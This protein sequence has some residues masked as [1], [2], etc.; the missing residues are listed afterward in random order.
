[1]INGILLI[2]K[3]AGWTSHDVVKKVKNLLHLKKAGHA[4]TLDPMATGLLLLCLNQATRHAT[5]LLAADKTYLAS[6]SL[7]RAT[8]T[9]DSEGRVIRE[10]PVPLLSLDKIKDVLEG[11]M[12]TIEQI[13]PMYSAIKHQGRPLYQW[14]RAGK[15][16]ERLPRPITIN[17]LKLL[18]YSPNRIDLYIECSKGTYIRS[19]V[20]AIAEKLGTV[21]HLTQLRRMRCG[22]FVVEKAISIQDL[23]RE[24]KNGEFDEE[25][26]VIALENKALQTKTA[27]LA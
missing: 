9:E 6:L 25:K 3:P 23:E 20:V 21:G 17:Q 2:D 12:G 19:L 24:V 10:R 13:P 15:T 22:D 11:F 8:D 18:K 1:M 27:M 5:C 7:G 4:G 26:R 14:A 16:I